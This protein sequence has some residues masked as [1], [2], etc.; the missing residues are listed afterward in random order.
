MKVTSGHDASPWAL[1]VIELKGLRVECI[2]GLYAEERTRPQLLELDLALH[3]DTRAAARG[4]GLVAT[5]DYARVAGELRFLLES[6]HFLLLETAADALARY[7]LAPPTLDTPHAKVES[8]TLTLKKPQALEAAVPALTVHRRREEM[9][10]EV[11][12]KGFGR[13]D[14]IHA[15]A[16]C[17][18]YRLRIS[19]GCTI[20]THVHRVMSE[21]E[22]VLSDGLLL[23]GSP[24]R[25]GTGLTW[26]REFPHRYDN[27]T[28]QELTVLCVDRPA[29]LPD[30][31]IEVLPPEGGLVMP[32]SEFYYPAAATTSSSLRDH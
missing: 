8:V 28:A 20:P 30:D 19:P 32:C 29:F 23:Q 2:V 6:A 1:D 21:R 10:Y 3:L 25:A 11:E 9:F 7:L 18:I 26:P 15:S 31:E 13:V 12:E 17:G 24:I 22:L 5:V 27:P 4:G 16:E 14:V